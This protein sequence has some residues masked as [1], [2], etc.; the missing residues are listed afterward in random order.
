MNHN[1]PHPNALQAI[2]AGLAPLNIPAPAAAQGANHLAQ[3]AG[4]LA[5]H[6]PP[7][8][9]QGHAQVQPQ[10]HAVPQHE[11]EPNSPPVAGGQQAAEPPAAPRRMPIGIWRFNP[12]AYPM[13]GR[14]LGPIFDAV[15]LDAAAPS[16]PE[17]RESRGRNS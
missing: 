17:I 15:P 6:I 3:A 4:Q 16:T 10:A 14:I 1:I 7:L 9:V 2:L 13:Q 5:G 11:D 8:A 12:P